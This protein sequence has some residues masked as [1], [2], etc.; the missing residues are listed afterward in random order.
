VTRREAD[1]LAW[2]AAEQRPISHLLAM[3]LESL[4][5]WIHAHRGLLAHQ[6]AAMAMRNALHQRIE[7]PIQDAVRAAQNVQPLRKAHGR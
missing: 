2:L 6:D 1:I 4:I 7:V 5:G 3:P